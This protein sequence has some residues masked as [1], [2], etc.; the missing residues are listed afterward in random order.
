MSEATREGGDDVAGEGE[1]GGSEG[2]D[3]QGCAGD[4]R[5]AGNRQVTEHLAIS[6]A[7]TGGDAKGVKRR[8][9]AIDEGD[10]NIAE[11]TSSRT[12]R[13]PRGDARERALKKQATSSTMYS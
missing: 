1:R 11:L 13:R 12:S 2:E 9:V 8:R 7:L 3:G 6:L 10:V 4:A 5:G